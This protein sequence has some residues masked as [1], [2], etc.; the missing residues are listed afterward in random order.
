M[1]TRCPGQ[2]RLA[3]NGAAVIDIDLAAAIALATAL[4]YDGRAVAELR[5]SL[6]AMSGR[7]G[8]LGSGLAPDWDRSVS[9]PAPR[10]PASASR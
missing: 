1:I 7:L 9:P 2:L 8:A 6:E 10:S 5:G 3:P 4:G